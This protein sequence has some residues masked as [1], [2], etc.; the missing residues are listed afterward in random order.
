MADSIAEKIIANIKTTLEGVTVAAGYN[1]TVKVVYRDP[2]AALDLQLYPAI[3]IA[4]GSDDTDPMAKSV[5]HRSLN[6]TLEIWIRREKDIS[7]AIESIRADVQ[8]A[9]MVDVRRGANA[10]NTLERSSSYIL[11]M[12]EIP[13]AAV[14]IGYTVDYRTKIEDPF[15]APA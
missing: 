3:F 8:K 9:M 7:Q 13:E 5:S 11:I 10:V 4:I 2:L 14:Q 15:S 6:F 12:G 1:N